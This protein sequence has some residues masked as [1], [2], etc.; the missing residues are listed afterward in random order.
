[1]A[2]EV[3]NVTVKFGGVT[4][5]KSFDM[6][7]EKNTIHS[8]IGPNG[9]GKTTLFNV[10]TRIVKE[11]EGKVFFNGEDLA[12]YKP[13]EVIKTGISRTFQN[14]EIFKYMTVKD[15]FF[16]GHHGEINY[17]IF[18]EILWTGKA[19]RIE[20]RSMEKAFEIA[21]LLG[22]KS[23]LNTLAGMLPYGL[24]KLVEIGRALMSEPEF[25]MLDEP[26]A[27]LNPTETSQLKLLIKRLRDEYNLTIFLV[28]HDMSL[29]MDISDRVTVMNFGEKIAEGS[30]YDIKNDPK[31]IEAY[32]GENKY[33]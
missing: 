31:V 5:V 16:V 6:F 25:L 17:G 22:L 9:A 11:T 14:L 3:K 8:L 10:I 27:G 33:A 13:Y 24:Q 15:N 19:K 4:A 20:K 7:V 23:R 2:L 18:Q 12:A 1:M 29:V 26:A 32:L 28:E 21:E 30:A